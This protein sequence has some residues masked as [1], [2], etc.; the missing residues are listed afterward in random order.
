MCGYFQFSFDGDIQDL[1]NS[2]ST[3]LSDST[4]KVDVSIPDRN[5][6]SEDTAVLLLSITF[7][8]G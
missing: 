2:F 1:L 3:R 7:T 5:Q 4:V 6:D 8:S